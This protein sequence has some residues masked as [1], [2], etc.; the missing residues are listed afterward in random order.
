M[1]GVDRKSPLN[2]TLMCP[3]VMSALR[4]WYQL[5]DAT[6]YLMKEKWSVNNGKAIQEIRVYGSAEH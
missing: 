2:S 3:I 5:V 4:R 1:S 6:L